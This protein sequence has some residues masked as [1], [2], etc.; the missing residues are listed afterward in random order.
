MDFGDAQKSGLDGVDVLGKSARFAVAIAVA[1]GV[2][3]DLKFELPGKITL[4]TVLAP[5]IGKNAPGTRRTR[6]QTGL[7]FPVPENSL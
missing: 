3:I 2:D 6:S 4:R 1:R 7:G 5:K